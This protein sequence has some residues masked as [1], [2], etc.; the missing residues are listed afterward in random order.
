MPKI[1][2]LKGVQ[3]GKWTVL[4]KAEK[5]GK[6]TYW[7]CRCGCGASREVATESLRKGQSKS[8]GCSSYDYRKHVDS[9]L[10]KDLTGK[11][12]GRLEVTKRTENDKNGR[13]VFWCKCECGK[14]I[15]VSGKSL[16]AGITKSCGCLRRDTTKERATTHGLGAH[17][18]R[19]TWSGM[20]QRCENPNNNSY[21]NY[22]GRDIKVCEEW[23]C[24]FLNFYTWSVGNGYKEN[25]T[26]ERID[27]NGNYCPD[28]CKWITSK[29]QSM[30]KTNSVYIEHK[31]ET[32]HLVE[33][34]VYFGVSHS[35]IQYHLEKG[36]IFNIFNKYEDRLTQK[37]E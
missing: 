1:L 32:K 4:G 26:I 36:N 18:I 5:R 21:K 24:D 11:K 35:T 29:E 27:V 20:K 25:L 28:N 31:G 8:C 19:R 6:R 13:A 3:F 14:K 12:F 2:E 9:P 7:A 17:R 16:S 22:G 30:N 34:A 37:K 33:W 10:L 23:K 15:K